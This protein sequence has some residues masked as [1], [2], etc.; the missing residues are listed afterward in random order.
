MPL[1]HTDLPPSQSPRVSVQPSVVIELEWALASG[2]NDRYRADHP[3]L[4]AMYQSHPDLLSRVGSIWGPGEAISCG[5]FMELMLLA[6]QGGLLFGTDV[7]PFLD[8]LGELCATAP[9]DLEQYLITETEEDRRAVLARLRRL[10]ESADLREQY[11]E[12]IRDMWEAIRPDWERSGRG[13]VEVAVAAREGIRAKGA[14]WH[15]V[16]R[17]ECDFGDLVDRTM[18]ELGPDA[19]LVVVPAFFTHRGLVIDLPGIVVL[20]VRTDITGAQARARTESL[21]RR[22]KAISDPTRLAMLDAL[23]NG[24]RTITDIAAAFALAQP[25]VSNHIKVLRHAGLVTDVRDGTRRQ[26]VV[27]SD[28]VDELLSN[29]HDVLSDR[30]ARVVPSLTT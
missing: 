3:V 7:G 20:G 24:P 9:T 11:V 1:L 22:L 25:T 30:D 27:Q 28:A 21:A 10:R 14:D 15:E 26:L 8:G 29:L 16:T 12:L 19:E 4:D 17:S 13:A 6:H 5:G 23:R 2:E 18:A